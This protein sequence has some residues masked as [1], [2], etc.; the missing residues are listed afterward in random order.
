M[1]KA[2]VERR[3]SISAEDFLRVYVPMAKA[4]KT[5]GE[6]GQA[7]GRDA[8][9]VTVKASQLRATLKAAGQDPALIPTL[10]SRSSQARDLASFIESLTTEDDSDE[11]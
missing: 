6:I 10:Q 4:G 8:S 9:Y 1:A 11:S 2:K 3:E 7:L 5:A